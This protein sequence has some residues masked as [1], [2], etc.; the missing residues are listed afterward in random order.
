MR[1]G[2]TLL[3]RFVLA[4]ICCAAAGGLGPIAH[5]TVTVTLDPSVEH[6]TVLGWGASSWSP[7]WTTAELREEVIR[8]AV[9]DLGL[10]RL[11]LEGPS[12]NRSNDRRWE[13]LNDNGDPE[14]I[15]WTAFN[16][17]RLDER[18][19]ETVTPYKEQVEA[20]GESFNCYV[21]PSLFDGG[22]SGESP[23]WLLHNPGEYAEFAAAFPLRLKNVHGIEADYY[24]IL[25]EAGNN[26]PFTAAVVGR[27]IKALGPRLEALRL[28]TK[29]QF[30]ECVNANTTTSRR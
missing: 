8:E 18:T 13:W 6:Q 16:T 5:S 21:S 11:R 19:T 15:D 20:N 14:N 4:S 1:N 7:P 22:S 23:P 24:C 9:N 10:T 12:G 25:N 30:P 17:A 28:R 3:K 27:M 26:N 2:T 29:I